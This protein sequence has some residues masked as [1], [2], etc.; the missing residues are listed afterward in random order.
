MRFG[1]LKEVSPVLS[2]LEAS[3]N[4]LWKTITTSTEGPLVDL[5]PPSKTMQV[6]LGIVVIPMYFLRLGPNVLNA[7]LLIDA[8]SILI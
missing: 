2:L 6:C 8:S 7:V 5:L 1:L 4:K 3:D